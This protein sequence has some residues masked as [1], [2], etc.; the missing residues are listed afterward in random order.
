MLCAGGVWAADADAT[1]LIPDY[2]FSFADSTFANDLGSGTKGQ[3]NNGTQD[4]AYVDSVNGKGLDLNVYKSAGVAYPYY[5]KGSG[6]SA[7]TL[8]NASN[9]YAIAVYAKFPASPTAKSIV[10]HSAVYNHE[11]GFT[12]INSSADALK[13]LWRT[14]SSWNT[15]PEIADL[16]IN[17]GAYHHI[18]L[19]VRYGLTS[20]YPA[21][22]TEYAN[23]LYVD[24]VRKWQY[25]DASR[26]LVHNSSPVRGIGLGCR[27]GY[28]TSP[29]SST[30]EVNGEVVIDDFRA[31]VSDTA[32]RDEFPLTSENVSALYNSLKPTVKTYTWAGAEKA[33]WSDASNWT[34]DGETA[35]L[36]P[37]GDDTVSITNNTCITVDAAQGIGNVVCS[38]GVELSLNVCFSAAGQTFTIPDVVATDNIT[39]QVPFTCTIENGV[40]TA[41]RSGSTNFTWNGGS[42]N[43]RWDADNFL[44]GTEVPSATPIA[45]DTVVFP[46]AAEGDTD[47]LVV[48]V[49]SLPTGTLMLN[50]DVTLTGTVQLGDVSGTGTLT[51]QN[52]NFTGAA[53]I[54]VPLVVKGSVNMTDGSNP[55]I[56]GALSGDGA[57]YCASSNQG[58]WQFNGD[59]SGFTGSYTGCNRASWSRDGT[60]FNNGLNGQNASWTVG[61]EG[62]QGGFKSAVFATKNATYRLGQIT[63]STFTM[64]GAGASTVEVGGK[65]NSESTISGEIYESSGVLRKVGETSTLAFTSGSATGT[66]E[67]EAGTV[68]LSG[69]APATI[70]L[71]GATAKLVTTLELE[72]EPVC[73][74]T[75]FGVSKEAVT[76][77]EVTTY[78]YSLKRK[79]LAIIVH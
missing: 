30:Y 61:Y 21:T 9:A 64:R 38:E 42:G 47:E 5:A 68:T 74:V 8:V 65:A 25:T 60:R 24:G 18:V 53:T 19:Q 27:V 71:T 34:V 73:G 69:T 32:A 59:V 29:V 39:A 35:T 62:T 75:G 50:R 67:I 78:T 79:G 46:A 12:L 23:E 45:T 7:D 58:G 57:I 36:S 63:S 37:S 6:T 44:V 3:A 14:S 56:N 13:I 49:A 52:M 72:N 70:K 48:T 76:V 40:A 20:R 11:Q 26:S 66:L 1:G 2:G 51:M 22:G 77:D 54:N 33:L 31:Y 17:D 43:K 55:V 10:F 16:G 28:A 4:G 41:V 15:Y